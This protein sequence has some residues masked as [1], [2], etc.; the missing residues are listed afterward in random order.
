MQRYRLNLYNTIQSTTIRSLHNMTNFNKNPYGIND[1]NSK[2]EY[3]EYIT[4]TLIQ[5]EENLNS[6][7]HPGCKPQLK[8]EGI[9]PI[10]DAKPTTD[11]VFFFDIDNCLYP[12]STKIHDV[13]QEYIHD[14]FVRTLSI[15]DDEAYKLHQDY[16][17]TYG[18]AIQGLVKFHKIDALEYNRKV[19]DALP[20]QNILKPDLKLRQLILDLKK[21]GKIDRLWL[22]TNAYK[23]HA[24]RV[25]S[26]LGIGDLFDG[27][28]Y[29]DYS[30]TSLICKPMESSFEKAM[31]EA[32][33]SNP[34]NCYFVDDSNSNIETSIK[35]GFKK[36]ILLLE[37][38]DDLVKRKVEGSIIIKNI[39]EL[40]DVVPELFQ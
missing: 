18:L 34:Q 15:T 35:L 20:L 19:D 31:K 13:M 25:I 27:L 28:T 7:T 10:P 30:E 36:N 33:V 11:K 22:F 32:N 29:C 23:N 9:N 3:D 24:K 21:T 37:T 38:D 14:Y 8:Y 12:R 4:K 39:L 2:K 5:N 40:R 26:L 1:H 17:K 6:L 16:Y